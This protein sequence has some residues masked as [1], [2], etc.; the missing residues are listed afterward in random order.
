M[1]DPHDILKRPIFTE[2]ATYLKETGGKLIVEVDRKANKVEIKDAFEKLFN[3]K[4]K[5]V[6]TINVPGKTKKWGRSVGRSAAMKKAIVTL[7]K[8]EK[9]DFIEG[10]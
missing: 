10:V 6:A 1:K 8:G 5:K 4:V 9:L 2:K 3:V 7:E